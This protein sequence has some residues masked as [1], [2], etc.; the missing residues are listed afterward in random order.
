[1]F[2]P[3]VLSVHPGQRFL[4]SFRQEQRNGFHDDIRCLQTEPPQRV[5]GDS[6][7]IVLGMD[8]H[9]VEGGQIPLQRHH[10]ADHA[11]LECADRRRSVNGVLAV[12]RRQFSGCQEFL[13]K[14]IQIDVDTLPDLEAQIEVDPEQK[15]RA[16]RFDLVFPLVR[17]VGGIDTDKPVGIRPLGVPVQ[18]G[19][20]DIAVDHLEPFPLG[21]IHKVVRAE[22]DVQVFLQ[23]FDI[24]RIIRQPELD[25]LH[26]LDLCPSVPAD[27]DVQ[28]QQ[29]KNDGDIAA[30]R[31]FA[32]AGHE[33]HAFDCAEDERKQHR[34]DS[35]FVQ[36]TD[37]H[38][39]QHRHH[40]HADRDRKTIRVL[41]A[42][43]AAEIQNDDHAQ[44]PK[45]FVDHGNVDLSF[46][47]GREPD[48]QVR[49]QIETGRFVHKRVAAADECLAGDDSRDGAEDDRRRPQ[50]RR[51]HH[52]ERI[53]VLD[54]G[55]RGIA[56]APDH[57][58]TLPHVVE[59]QAQFDERPADDDIL[60]ADMAHI[61]VQRFRTGGAEEYAAE[62]HETGF[63]SGAEQDFNGVDRI[64]CAEDTEVAG[65]KHGPG[66]A[67]EQEPDHHDRSEQPADMAR[68]VFLDQ[69][70]RADDGQRDH[71]HD[72]LPASEQLVHDG[73]AAE[74]FHRRCH[75]NSRCEHT[76][77]KHGA[78]ADHRRDD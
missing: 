6:A 64:E 76:V 73:D 14:L 74:S 16:E 21:K 3:V 36:D 18:D 38:R 48:I 11:E 4:L 49:H 57:P 2:W 34:A 28:D 20:Q 69:E 65:E 10:L 60:L 26:M 47:V 68:S 13:D 31:E 29:G 23:C 9:A 51:E 56:A 33:E 67:E 37:I 53:D 55:K 42:R 61:G 44:R 40:Q 39:E 25:V 32:E 52:I 63:V 58:R 46:R 30:D 43:A 54:G 66:D 1:M 35:S 62:D 70:Q 24:V 8:Q 17:L 71:D 5:A 59:D 75:C 45:E 15:I 27:H 22:R 78:A 41:Y 7:D 50:S 12:L 72:D 19:V 77:G